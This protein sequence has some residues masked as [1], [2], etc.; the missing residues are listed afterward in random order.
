MRSVALLF[1]L[2]LV[3]AFTA[4][5]GFAAEQATPP[6]CESSGNAT[7]GPAAGVDPSDIDGLR[8]LMAKDV[9]EL[10]ALF[11]ADSPDNE[12]ARVLTE[13]IILTRQALAALTGTL[14]P[15][16][17]CGGRGNGGDCGG[18]QSQ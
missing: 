12:R 15:G 6:C 10:H 11:A 17:N 13:R 16:T 4:A 7:A 1:I 3:F 14:H 2:A 9:A 18:C 8:Q 5:Q